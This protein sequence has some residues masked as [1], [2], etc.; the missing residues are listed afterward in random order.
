MKPLLISLFLVLAAVPARATSFSYWGT[1]TETVVSTNDPAFYVG[2]QLL[3]YYRYNAPSSDGDFYIPFGATTPPGAN[4]SLKGAVYVTFPPVGLHSLQSTPGAGLLTVTDG[5]VTNFQW[6]F[7]VGGRYGGF[8]FAQF[9]TGVYNG[10]SGYPINW[11]T[12]TLTF[13]AATIPDGGPTGWLLLAGVGCCAGLGRR[14]ARP[15]G[16]V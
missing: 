14:V 12:G 4:T 9:S 10:D 11:T 1:I 6:T 13:G 5:I 7:D 2:E 16:R 8:T 3:G 15:A